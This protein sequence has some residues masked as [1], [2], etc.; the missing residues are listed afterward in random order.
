MFALWLIF[1]LLWTTGA[2]LA[3]FILGLVLAYLLLPLVGLLSRYMPRWAAITLIYVVG[4][5]VVVT[6]LVLV[7][8]PVINQ[9]G[10]FFDGLPRFYE[11]TVEPKVASVQQWYQSTVPE[12]VQAQIDPQVNNAINSLKENA[13]QYASD[14]GASLLA[15]ITSVFRTIVFLAGFLIIPFWLFY[16]L[17]DEQKGK[18]MLDRLLPSRIRADFWSIVEIFDRTFSDYVRGQ[19]TLG[20]IVGIMSYVGLWIV[21]L[22]FGY[23]VPYKLLLALVAGA[24]ELIPVIGPVIGAIPAVIVGLTSSVT[25]GLVIVGLYVI[26]QQLEN[27]VLVPR[28]IGG[29]VEL[30]A[31][32]LMLLLVVAASV[33]GLIAVILVAP[34]TAVA[35]DLYRYINARLQPRDSVRYLP[36][37]ALPVNAAEIDDMDD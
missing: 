27:N 23:D 18:A 36:A 31:S 17:L 32:V 30:H 11:D 20:V 1:W 33:G 6:A 2:A 16:V 34:V 21:D 5:G 8:P 12:Q 7:V 15:G 26:I 19:I 29:V 25:A 35:R 10:E 24:T 22:V 28:I 3:P 9:V 37:G 4:I 13:S 14:V